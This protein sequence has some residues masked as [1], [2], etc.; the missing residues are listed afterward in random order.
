MK[1]IT[2]NGIIMWESSEGERYLELDKKPDTEGFHKITVN[3][4]VMWE[5]SEGERVLEP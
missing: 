5:S 4:K 3:G 1:K 2:V